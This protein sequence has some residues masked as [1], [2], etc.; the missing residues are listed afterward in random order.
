MQNF[1]APERCA[2]YRAKFVTGLPNTALVSLVDSERT[3][4]TLSAI[5]DLFTMSSQQLVYLEGGA[6][7]R[8]ADFWRP[9]QGRLSAADE[10]RPEE[11]YQGPT[12]RVD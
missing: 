1:E 7:R 2:A 5:M 4:G 12:L 8:R 10:R 9:M 3:S 11:V 6:G